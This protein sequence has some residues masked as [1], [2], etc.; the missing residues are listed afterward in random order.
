MYE[1]MNGHFDD[2]SARCL[3]SKSLVSRRLVALDICQEAQ[4]VQDSMLY[5]DRA[6]QEIFRDVQAKTNAATSSKQ[7]FGRVYDGLKWVK[8]ERGCFSLLVTLVLGVALPI[9]CFLCGAA[10]L[11]GHWGLGEEIFVHR[12]ALT[13]VGHFGEWPFNTVEVISLAFLLHIWCILNVG[14]FVRTRKIYAEQINSLKD[15]DQNLLSHFCDVANVEVLQC[16]SSCDRFISS[17]R[18]EPYEK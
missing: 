15:D 4:P 12:N 14:D 10:S 3:F 6:L 5:K 13:D 11:F 16:A 9:I 18:F 2:S 8:Q 17:D 7:Y 1:K